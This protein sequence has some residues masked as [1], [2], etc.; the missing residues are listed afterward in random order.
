[1]EVCTPD[2]DTPFTPIKFRLTTLHSV[3][4]PDLSI[5][6]RMS[7]AQVFRVSFDIIGFLDDG[8]HIGL[9]WHARE[10]K[11]NGGVKP[12]SLRRSDVKLHGSPNP[13]L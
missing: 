11:R 6:F 12:R 9:A 3:V 8:I 13:A 7:P 5:S 2:L 4:N 1:M 10:T